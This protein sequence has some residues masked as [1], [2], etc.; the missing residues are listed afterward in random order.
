MTSL[1]APFKFTVAL[2][3]FSDCF[4]ALAV[5]VPNGCSINFTSVTDALPVNDG[6]G[7]LRSLTVAFIS[8]M[9][10]SKIVS[11]FTNELILFKLKLSTTI[12]IGLSATSCLLLISIFAVSLLITKLFTTIPAGP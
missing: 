6:K 11:L 1:S 8:K 9:P 7:F 5:M 3:L 2:I 12:S 4:C 10:A